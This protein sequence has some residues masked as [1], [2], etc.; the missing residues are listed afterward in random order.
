VAF[1]FISSLGY[2]LLAEGY[3][4]LDSIYMTVI[5]VTTVGFHEVKPLNDV[6]R[7]WTMCVVVTGLVIGTIV[8]T[9]AV[10]AVVEGEIRAIFGRRQL[11]RKVAGLEGHVI[12]CGYG[13]MGALVAQRLQ[14]AG[15]DVVV[16]DSNTA[17][18]TAAQ[19][20]G[21][22][23]VLG[24]AQDEGTLQAAGI[25]RAKVLVAMLP[26]DAENVFV[27]LTARQ[28]NDRVR[29]VARAERPATQDKLLA[30]GASRVVCPQTLGA[31]QVGDMVLRPAVVDFVEMAH[32]GIDLEMDQLVLTEQCNLCGKTLREL[33]LPRRAGVQVVAV[34][35]ADGEAVYHPTPDLKLAGGDTL[36][37]VGKRGA[38]TAIQDMQPSAES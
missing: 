30:A 6:G 32:K 24:D 26:T 37:L 20:A 13:N 23:Y 12:L 35:R 27:T 15:R 25:R 18:T 7:I 28:A 29:I 3:G 14:A 17:C 19:E 22:L 5:T 31:M 33:A 10:G 2:R 4:W 9:M 36:V 34:R 1:I 8:L 21:L 38:A 16:V 11:E